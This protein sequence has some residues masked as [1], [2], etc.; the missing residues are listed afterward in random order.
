[1]AT[2]DERIVQ[3][4]GRAKVYRP[5]PPEARAEAVHAGFRHYEAG[6]SFEAHEAWEPAWM[7]TDDL[8][9]RAL[10]QGLIKIA[11]AEV[12]GSRGNAA[13]V[14]R[15]L[16]GALDRLRYARAAGCAAAPGAVID[17]DA[18][19]ARGDERLA[20][21]RSGDPGRSIVIPWRPEP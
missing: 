8:A 17:L 21:A 13:G 16:E 14:V 7:G 18:L 4:D 11:A 5:L 3:A 12:H 6:E 10:L 15:N 1:M 9:E 20:T 2:T 19:I